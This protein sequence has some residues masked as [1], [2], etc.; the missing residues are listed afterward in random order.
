MNDI[1][2]NGKP[3]WDEGCE[4]A[5][6]NLVFPTMSLS[7]PIVSVPAPDTESQLMKENMMPCRTDVYRDRY[8]A[9]CAF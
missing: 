3:T 1:Q 9:L 2:Q 5:A 7:V 8:N 6:D 4:A